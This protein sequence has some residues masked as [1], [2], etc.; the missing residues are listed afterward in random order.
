VVAAIVRSYH[1]TDFL[2]E[3]L[4]SLNW[5]DKILVVNCLHEGYDPAPDD[6]EEIVSNLNQ[7]NVHLMK[8]SPKK[9][10][11]VLNIGISHLQEYDNILIC[12]ADEFIEEKEWK[13]IIK[14]FKTKMGLVRMV[15]YYP[16]GHTEER[17]HRPAMIVKPDTTFIFQRCSID[18]YQI[19]TDV[20]VKH[21]GYCVKDLEWKKNNY[22]KMGMDEP[23]AK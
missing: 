17:G 18:D 14:R 23:L 20:C 19:F 6:T 7:S 3:V 8:L 16:D 10:H 21:Y 5:V 22:I 4:I 15:D 11:I 2:K 1:N 9:E 13:S 12:D